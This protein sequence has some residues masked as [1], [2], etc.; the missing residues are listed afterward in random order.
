MIK[1]GSREGV[2]TIIAIA[3]LLLS[4]ISVLSC[5]RTKP[6]ATL[7]ISTDRRVIEV[8]RR[9]SESIRTINATLGLTPA[10]IKAPELSAYMSFSREGLFRFTGFTPTGFTLFNFETRD[11]QFTL[12]LSNGTKISGDIDEVITDIK[13]LSGVNL[14]VYPGIVREA[15]DFYGSDDRP[16]AVFLIEDIRDY[17]ILNQLRSDRDISYP[18]RRWWIDKGDMLV[19]RKEIFS[20]L[21][22]ERGERL[23]EVLYGDFRIVD[24]IQ[25]PFEVII[26]G[27]KG[28]KLL[29]MKFYKVEYN[30][31]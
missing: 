21:P 6:Y 22:D 23:F 15:I 7:E 14:P 1:K 27:K 19:V 5:A 28:K 9:R 18:V 26:K 16:D 2:R 30:K 24:N 4:C 13:G 10:A 12:S 3:V 11:S 31:N 20:R 25:T 17:Y 8:I 29:K